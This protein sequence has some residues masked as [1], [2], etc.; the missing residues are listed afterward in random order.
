MAAPK[1][2]WGKDAA[3]KK[4]KNDEN[5]DARGARGALKPVKVK[6]DKE[7]R[8]TILDILH[9]LHVAGSN[10]VAQEGADDDTDDEDEEV[11]GTVPT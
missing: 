8:D 1:K 6:L 11:S 5:E 4:S 2:V 3:G 9:Q 7:G 10:D